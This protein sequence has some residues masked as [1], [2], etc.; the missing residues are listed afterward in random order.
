MG[1]F[2]EAALGLSRSLL[3]PK[4]GHLGSEVLENKR[5]TA[6]DTSAWIPD[7]RAS[8][9]DDVILTTAELAECTC[10]DPCECDHDS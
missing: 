10:P 7:E 5:M 8:V 6:A 4:P 1:P 3:D 2:Y 9:G